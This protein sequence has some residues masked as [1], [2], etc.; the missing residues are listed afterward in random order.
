MELID[1]SHQPQPC[2]LTPPAL[3]STRF[4]TACR[5]VIRSRVTIVERVARCVSHQVPR[6]GTRFRSLPDTTRLMI[7]SAEKLDRQRP[8]P[9]RSTSQVVEREARAPTPASA[10]GR[11]ARVIHGGRWC[12]RL[13]ASRSRRRSRYEEA[14]AARRVARADNRVEARQPSG[15]L[16]AQTGQR[17]AAGC[18]LRFRAGRASASA[19]TADRVVSERFPRGGQRRALSSRTAP[20]LPRT[21]R[22]SAI[23]ATAVS[24]S[25]ADAPRLPR[26]N[27]RA[28]RRPGSQR[29][30]PY[31]HPRDTQRG[32]ERLIAT[33]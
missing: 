31:R 1:H 17:R 19:R 32:S 26:R 27:A 28:T 7:D 24:A 22:R 25:T 4:I 8:S 16:P 23:G 14:A 29:P 5:R 13:Q 30:R 11:G 9:P 21:V 20:G 15:I 3:F 6:F 18:A 2:H 12:R 33:V 10:T